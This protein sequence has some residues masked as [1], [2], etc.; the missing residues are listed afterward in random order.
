MIYF[1]YQIAPA[2]GKREALITENARFKKIIESHG[3]KAVGSF[4]VAL[5]Q[6]DGNLVYMIAYDDM[7][8]ATKAGEALEKDSDYAALLKKTEPM[9]ASSSS[10]LLQPLPDSGL[11]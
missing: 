5:G 4:R 8:T 2:P 9:I 11:Q 7:A 1:G 10:L 3:G 6:G